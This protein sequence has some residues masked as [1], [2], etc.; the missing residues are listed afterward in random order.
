[1]GVHASAITTQ[2]NFLGEGPLWHPLR[3]EFLWFDIMNKTL[4]ALKD[5]A[6][7][8][9]GFPDLVSAAGWVDETRLVIASE[10][11]LFVFDL[12]TGTST[13]L[14]DLEADNPVTRSNDGRADHQGGFWIGTMGKKFEEGAGAIYRYYKGELRKLFAA[15]T[16]PNSICF[17]PD[18]NIAY[19][20]STPD[21]QIMQVGLNADGWP[22]GP[23]SVF[24]DLRGEDLNPDGSVVDAEGYVWNAQWG[25]GRVARYAP[26]GKL[27]RVV[28]LDGRHSSCPAFGGPDLQDLYITSAQEGM[29]APDAPQGLLYHARLEVKGLA[30]PRV[31]LP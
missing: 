30:E 17:S 2:P 10:R 18:G 26:D 13:P 27:E 8:E 16:I 1:M 31:I 12:D 21:Q 9:Y 20:C 15:V 25:R 24:I 6:Q 14:C 7:R 28:T 23:I 3:G 11:A 22:D 29:E 4:F 5:G 19:F